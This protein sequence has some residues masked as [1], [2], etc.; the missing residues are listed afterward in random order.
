MRK[1]T[2]VVLAGLPLVAFA[3]PAHAAWHSYV[4]HELGFS[5]EAPGEVKSQTG[6]SRAEIAGPRQTIVFRSVDDNIEYKVT[7]VK[8]GQ[9]QMD[10][11]DLLGERVF[12]YEGP[13]SNEGVHDES[14]VLMDTFARVEPGKEAVYGRKV[15]VNRP[16]NGGRTLAAF[17]FTKGKLYQL[18]ATVLPA[19]GDYSTP[20]AASFI[21]SVT[22]NLDRAVKSAAECFL[23]LRSQSA[24][25]GP[26]GPK[27]DACR[28]HRNK[29][30][31][32]QIKNAFDHL[33]RAR[34]LQF[35][36]VRQLAIHKPQQTGIEHCPTKAHIKQSPFEHA[37]GRMPG[38]ARS[39]ATCATAFDTCSG[40]GMAQSGPAFDAARAFSAEWATKPLKTSW[41]KSEPQ[42]KGWS[43]REDLNL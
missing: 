22:F 36:C 29:A 17:Y 20:D 40:T 6:T 32:N 7:V 31:Q 37:H 8:F 28:R 4:S 42:C 19:N 43:E 1:I 18:E 3:A 5:F 12:T 39:A 41:G 11:A 23:R 14:R 25:L 38:R 33:R 9:A 13:S 24:L 21:D 35:K 34:R 15:T 30:K 2:F 10:G 27:K 16:N 26:F